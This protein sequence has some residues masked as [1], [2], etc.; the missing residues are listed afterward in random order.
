MDRYSAPDVAEVQFSTTLTTGNLA[1]LAV[2]C[3]LA[4]SMEPE[5]PYT[6]FKGIREETF[7]F[8]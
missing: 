5:V 3:G 2:I 7:F 4:T 1:E 6:Y 8:S